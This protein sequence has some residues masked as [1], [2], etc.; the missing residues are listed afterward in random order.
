MPL[1]LHFPTCAVSFTV[2]KAIA[3]TDEYKRLMLSGAHLYRLLDPLT[4]CNLHNF[5]MRFTVVVF[6]LVAGLSVISRVDSSGY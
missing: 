3:R 4:N 5:A 2:L 6:V 1:R